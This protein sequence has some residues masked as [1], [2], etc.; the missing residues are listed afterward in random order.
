LP[1]DK[2]IDQEV[3]AAAS[4]ARRDSDPRLSWAYSAGARA[5]AGMKI[6][7]AMAPIVEYRTWAMGLGQLWSARGPARVRWPRTEPLLATCLKHGAPSCFNRRLPS[8]SAPDPLCPVESTGCLLPGIWKFPSHQSMDPHYRTSRGEGAGG[9]RGKGLSSRSARPIELFAET[10]WD[11]RTQ[12]SANRVAGC[13]WRFRC[14][15]G[16]HVNAGAPFLRHSPPS[17]SS[18]AKKL[19]SARITIERA[20]YT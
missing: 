1:N 13:L 18:H 15:V 16:S 12:R 2:E 17:R 10:W 19:D 4:R 8:H 7:D 5:S 3:R 14:S 6:P 11:E 20:G 9:P